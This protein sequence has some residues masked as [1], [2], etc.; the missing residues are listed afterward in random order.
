MRAMQI[1]PTLLFQSTTLERKKRF[2]SMPRSLHGNDRRGEGFGIRILLPRENYCGVSSGKQFASNFHELPRIQD[3]YSA[4][5]RKELHGCD[6]AGSE[7]CSRV[8]VPATVSGMDST[9]REGDRACQAEGIRAEPSLD[10]FFLRS[11]IEMGKGIDPAAKLLTEFD[12][13]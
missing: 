1:V 8:A 2:A 6:L 4:T 10:S 11:G 12:N 7:G 9:S 13:E 5:S 3:Q